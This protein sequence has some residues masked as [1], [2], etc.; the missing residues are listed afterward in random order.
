M[1]GNAPSYCSGASVPP[2]PGRTVDFV[3]LLADVAI[4]ADHMTALFVEWLRKR[5]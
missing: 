4:A 5:V 2:A 1:A 3:G